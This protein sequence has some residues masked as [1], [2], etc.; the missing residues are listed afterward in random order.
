MRQVSSVVISLVV[1]VGVACSPVGK[2][3][4]LSD[5]NGPLRIDPLQALVGHVDAIEARATQG[6]EQ[7]RYERD[8]Q[9]ELHSYRD[10]GEHDGTFPLEPCLGCRS[11]PA[12]RV[13]H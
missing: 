7:Y 8:Q 2:R 6:G 13:C 4:E 9:S 10:I 11:P 3:S 5:G 12:R 1:A